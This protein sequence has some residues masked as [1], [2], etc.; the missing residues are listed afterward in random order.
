MDKNF[1]ELLVK[2]ARLPRA[3]QRWILRQLSDDQLSTFNQNQGM[4]L[5]E[6]A[7]RFR[8]LKTKN[9]LTLMNNPQTLDEKDPLPLFCEQLA[10]KN[11]LYAAVVIEQGGYPWESI[12]LQKFDSDGLIKKSLENQVPDL[13]ALVKNTLFKEWEQSLSFENHLENEN[14]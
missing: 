5:L 7:Q 13:K 14:G 11:P 6:E 9:L 4:E 8:N 10:K 12:F 3:D 1:K 2:I